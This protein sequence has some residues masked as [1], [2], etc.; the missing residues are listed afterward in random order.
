[1]FYRIIFSLFVIVGLHQVIEAQWVHS[2]GPW[3]GRP[4]CLAIS[5]GRLFS[6]TMYGVFLWDDNSKSWAPTNT[7]LTRLET[8]SLARSGP[9]LL[10]GSIE[11]VF[12]SS[13][14]GGTWTGS[15][16]GLSGLN[17]RALLVKPPVVLAGTDGGGI[18]L[19]ADN[20]KSWTESNSGLTSTTVRTLVTNGADVFAGTSGGGVFIS[21]NNGL[22]WNESNAGLTDLDVRSLFLE[23]STLF[24]GTDDTGVFVSTNMGTD[25]TSVSDGLTTSKIWALAAF[26]SDILAG[27]WG[28]GIF[29]STDHGMHWQ[30]SDAGLTER[31]VYSF[32]TYGNE[33]FTATFSGVFRS[34]NGGVDWTGASTGMNSPTVEDFAVKNGALLAAT[35][36]GVFRTDPVEGGWSSLS[37][38][39]STSIIS[40]FATDDLILA[41]G[42][43]LHRSTD[44][45]ME[46]TRVSSGLP[47]MYSPRALKGIEPGVIAGGTDGAFISTTGGETWIDANVGLARRVQCFATDSTSLV[48]G[49][50]Y[51]VFLSTDNGQTWDSLNGTL[52]TRAV[53][54]DGSTILAGTANG[55][56]LSNNTGAT[57]V[58]SSSGLTN[59]DVWSLLRHDNFM[60]AGTSGGVFRSTDRGLH[61]SSFGPEL[62]DKRLYALLTNDSTLY[63]GGQGTGVWKR[64]LFVFV[65][66]PAAVSLQYPP[67]LATVNDKFTSFRWERSTPLV[68]RYWFEVSTDSQFTLSVMDSAVIDTQYAYRSLVSG[69]EYWWRVRAHN[70]TGWGP[71]GSVRSFTTSTPVAVPDQVTLLSPGNMQQFHGVLRWQHAKS[72]VDRHWIELSSDSLFSSPEIDSTLV[73]TTYYPQSVIAP[74][75]YWWHVRAHNILG[76][77]QFSN[78]NTFYTYLT[79][80]DNGTNLPEEYS[81]LQNYPNPFNPTTNIG[82]EIADFGLV[83]LAVYDLLGREVAVLVNE[84]MRPGTYSVKFDASALAG[85][86][87]LYRLQSADFV[88][89]RKLLLLK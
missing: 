47:P 89:T 14:N 4:Y 13:D 84:V 26:G 60:F 23:D 22:S 28:G 81:L 51:G 76:W 75:N 20:G 25:W 10:A 43:G 16:V 55:V 8:Y 57:W 6:G 58:R 38:N 53:I 49:T 46:W 82:F 68:D 78:A 44:D 37:R 56:F 79:Y 40:I 24:A 86:V 88:Q 67:D 65:S 70:E 80:V 72:F 52:D 63:A 7:G 73:D 29:R 3:V 64:P 50:G 45:G 61:W 35:P 2:G 85:A 66:L 30:K 12:I 77:G 15:G 48:A 18:Y 27:T 21:T 42:N 39:L 5:E 83:R 36:Y 17:V 32:Q 9:H 59:I 54:V 11:G 74:A 33:L 31:F 34:S 19:S 69:S 1:M 87:Y 41:G 71:F 62:N